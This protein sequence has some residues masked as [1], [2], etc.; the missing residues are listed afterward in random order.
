MAQNYQSGA[1]EFRQ[2]QQPSRVTRFGNLEVFP[3]TQNG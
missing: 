3:C 2:R 1:E